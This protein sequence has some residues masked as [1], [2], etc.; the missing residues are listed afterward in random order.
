MQSRHEETRRH[1][2]EH[3]G[4][5]FARS[6]ALR[7]HVRSVTTKL[8]ARIAA[9]EQIPEHVL[10]SLKNLQS[11]RS[12]G[13][14]RKKVVNSNGENDEERDEQ[15]QSHRILMVP[16]QSL[17][18]INHQHPQMQAYVQQ[19]QPML[20]NPSSV[21]SQNQ[22]TMQQSISSTSN[23]NQSTSEVEEGSEDVEED[24]T[25]QEAAETDGPDD[26]DE[27]DDD[28]YAPKGKLK[29]AFVSSS[30]TTGYVDAGDTAGAIRSST[31]K[32]RGRARQRMS[33]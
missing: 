21:Q 7:R 3:C 29:R 28:E 5:T 10:N 1:R 26:Q 31:R 24:E 17:Q 30:E 33:P 12:A 22:M 8:E 11:A 23:I 25:R 19:Y 13:S 16:Q 14:R 2:C 18:Y 27:E 15:E 9:G 6:D 20:T 4:V 32:T